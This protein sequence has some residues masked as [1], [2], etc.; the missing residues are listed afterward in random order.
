[1]VRWSRISYLANFGRVEIL[2]SLESGTQSRGCR[3][4]CTGATQAKSKQQKR[5]E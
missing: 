3:L 4:L 2:A 5:V 1:M